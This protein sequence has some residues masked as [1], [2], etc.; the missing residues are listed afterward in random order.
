MPRHPRAVLLASALVLGGLL[1]CVDGT[2][3]VDPAAVGSK[4]S[5]AVLPVFSGGPQSVDATPVNLIRLTVLRLPEEERVA[6]SETSVDPD[7]SEWEVGIDVPL[8]GGADAQYVLEVE[9]I[10]RQGGVDV[11][12]WSGRAGPLTLTP[13]G[14]SPVREVGVTRG[15]L[16]NLSVTG[17]A[18]DGPAT[19]P[20]QQDFTLTAAVETSSSPSTPVVFWTSLDPTVASVGSNGQGRT[21][22]AGTA[23]IQ[24]QAGPV[25]VVHEIQ[26]T[27]VPGSVEVTPSEV[28]LTGVGQLAKFFA[29]VRDL[30]GTEMSDAQVTWTAADGRIVETVGDGIFRALGAGRTNITA[31]SVDA[32]G[33]AG[34]ASVQ[35]DLTPVEMSLSPAALTLVRVGQ[36]SAITANFYAAGKV[37]VYGV[38]TTWTSSDPSVATVNA[39]GVITAVAEGTTVITAETDPLGDPPAPLS[40]TAT[41]TVKFGVGSVRVAP[42][43][44]TLTLV[45]QQQPLQAAAYDA[46][47]VPI[48]SPGVVWSSSDPSVATVSSSGV[49]TAVADGAAGITAT[50]GPASATA[51][52]TVDI[53]VGKVDVTPAAATLDFGTTVTLS[54]AVF[55]A[56]GTPVAIPVT[57]S[58]ADNLIATV[59][60]DG[61]VTGVE[62]GQTD[63][64]ATAKGTSGSATITVQGA[65][66]PAPGSYSTAGNTELVT[67]SCPVPVTAHVYDA[68]GLLATTPGLTVTSTGSQPTSAGGSVDVNA[69]GC[70]AYL[71]PSGFQGTDQFTYTVDTGA[72]ATVQISVTGMIWYV[73]AGG[74]GDGTSLNWLPFTGGSVGQP[75][76][77]I[78]VYGANPIAG[79]FTLQ[80]NQDLI[81]EGTGLT[82]APF[83]QIH[84]PGPTPQISSSGAGIT[85]AD[86]AFVSGLALVATDDGIVASGTVNA[87]VENVLIQGS[88]Y[89]GVALN[90]VIGTLTFNN[91]MINGAAN[92]GFSVTGGSPSATVNLGGPV[93]IQGAA[94]R[95]VRVTGTTGGQVTF[96]GGDISSTNQEGVEIG[97]ASGK[98]AFNSKVIVTNPTSTPGISMSGTAGDVVFGSAVLTTTGQDGV[99]LF[100]NTGK[101]SVLAGTVNTTD[102]PALNINNAPFD[103]A[104]STVAVSSTNPNFGLLVVG[105]SPGSVATIGSLTLN[106]VGGG[107]PLVLNGMGNF[108]ASGGSISSTTGPAVSIVGSGLNVALSSVS[109]TT[110]SGNAIWIQGSGGSFS[111][112][113]GALTTSGASAVTLDGN[114]ALDFTYGGTISNTGGYSVLASNNSGAGKVFTFGGDITDSSQGIQLTSNPGVTTEFLGNLDVNVYGF[115]A[116]MATGGNT[117][118]VQGGTNNLSSGVTVGVSLSELQGTNVIQNATISSGN[119]S[120]LQLLQ[121]AASGSLTITGSTISNSTLGG[122]VVSAGGSGVMDL[123][124]SNSTLNNNGVAPGLSVSSSASASVTATVNGTTVFDGNS[125]GLQVGT[126]GNGYLGF[127]VDGIQVLNSSSSAIVAVAGTSTGNLEGF[128]TNNTVNGF[129]SAGVVIQ[130]QSSG[131]GTLEVS[132]NTF[133]STDFGTTG[134]Q[135]LGGL[136]SGEAGDLALT[137]TNNSVATSQYGSGFDIQSRYLTTLCANVQGNSATDPSGYGSQGIGV[138]QGETSTFQLERF[139]GTGT[140]TTDVESHLASENPGIGAF[141]VGSPFIAFI[142]QAFASPVANGTCRTPTALPAVP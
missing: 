47:G 136:A 133:T 101:F 37:P 48:P 79:G 134:V 119:G 94:K 29:T 107:T 46:S 7:A 22:R 140:L 95:V 137:L 112:T 90:N 103:V 16:D 129:A 43:A 9:L 45:G 6:R 55:D 131:V 57:W 75:G 44:A 40:A 19:V 34:A 113:G 106:S 100:N 35:V 30:S 128:I 111:A 23:R 8:S 61:V 52:I 62:P 132:N 20:E 2:A 125:I 60:V 4:A 5:L 73:G 49:V 102:M 124:I 115:P 82:V 76:D 21:L 78:Y 26:V 42:T 141:G 86:G 3:P 114:G 13:G 92:D 127:D 10:T 80:A 104:F 65:A 56:A 85:L 50:V 118:Q 110:T 142:D 59:T 68:A 96:N 93:G 32:P 33:V 36:T 24:A 120:G 66:A 27:P 139:T 51:A 54:A 135:V 87:T 109:S 18:V 84:P 53:T 72:S 97:S 116:L 28:R 98:V 39:N 117:I 31:T 12:Q 83:G 91:L 63:V 108:S 15:P 69:D 64:T 38:P 67:G 105:S 17:L 130:S 70:F 77:M 122:V 71:P 74:A 14:A 25:T 1:S 123:T 138:W 88:T 89:D 58:S 11:V 41:V 99:Y 81:G 126:S 121:N